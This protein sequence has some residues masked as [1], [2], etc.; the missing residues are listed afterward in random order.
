MQNQ[1]IIIPNYPPPPLPQSLSHP[2]CW[3]SEGRLHLYEQR[4][5][6]YHFE[7]KEA[8]VGRN[9]EQKGSDL[10]RISDV[11]SELQKALGA[12]EDLKNQKLE[13]Q[14]NIE[15]SSEA[16]WTTK[17]DD[18]SKNQKEL[19]DLITK[20]TNP[21]FRNVIQER[22][23]KRQVKRS[24]IKK[25][26]EQTREWKQQ[27]LKERES[28]NAKIDA[29]FHTKIAENNEER[30]K[31]DGL[32][33]AEQILS[34]VTKKKTEAKRYISLLDSLV[35]LR[36]VR[37]IQS[38]KNDTGEGEFV[39]KIGRLKNIW[40]DAIENYGV[41]EKE[42]QKF[43]TDKSDVSGYDEWYEALFGTTRG[44]DRNNPML[45]SEY[46]FKEFLRNR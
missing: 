8:A 26:K 12:I 5:R 25:R 37:R 46:N 21:D 30:R 4:L 41:D 39:A 32:K 13:L 29:W 43:L 1:S 40:N 44:V 42:L 22:I 35:E 19:T 7:K 24:R 15:S 14:R 2:V 20:Y 18:I 36:R 10:T 3:N 34:G 45:R 6:N 16:E 27:L 38:G 17:I 23:S 28:K 9:Y 33:R 31:I 11:K